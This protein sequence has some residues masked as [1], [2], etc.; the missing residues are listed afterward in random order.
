MEYILK[1]LSKEEAEYI[2]VKINGIV[3]R[4]SDGEE[5]KLV[6]NPVR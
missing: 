5:E 3:P 4:E 6:L 2:G 1:D